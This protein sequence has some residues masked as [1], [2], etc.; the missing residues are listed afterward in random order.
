[1]EK[2]GEITV[3]NFKRLFIF[4]FR[5]EILHHKGTSVGRESAR[6]RSVRGM[7]PETRVSETRYGTLVGKVI[8]RRVSLVDFSQ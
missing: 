4:F 1:M 7:V 5:R 3:L 8:P 6:L 2:G